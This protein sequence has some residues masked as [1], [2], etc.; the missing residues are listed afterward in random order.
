MPVKVETSTHRQKDNRKSGDSAS[1]QKSSG[2][3]NEWDE[4]CDNGND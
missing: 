3:V 2:S 4:G 1:A